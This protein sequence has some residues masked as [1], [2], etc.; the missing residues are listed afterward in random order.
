MAAL[1]GAQPRNNVLH[2]RVL[3]ASLRPQ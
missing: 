1:A 3:A 2:M